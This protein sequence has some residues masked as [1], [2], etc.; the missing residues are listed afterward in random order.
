VLPPARHTGANDS[1]AAGYGRQKLKL[2]AIGYVSARHGVDADADLVRSGLALLAQTALEYY[3]ALKGAFPKDRPADPYFLIDAVDVPEATRARQRLK[4]AAIAYVNAR[5]GM[6]A[7]RG[8]S[9]AGLALLAQAA[10]EY[11]E[12]LAA[13]GG[14][15]K[16]AP[17]E[18]Q[19]QLGN[20]AR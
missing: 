2:A 5:H 7:D 13:V 3:E 15:S 9:I 11:Y 14:A 10:L 17:I 1:L 8:M 19:R 18:V 20:G 16:K 12:V 4:L 6:D